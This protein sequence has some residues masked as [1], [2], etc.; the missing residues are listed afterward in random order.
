MNWTVPEIL[1]HRWIHRLFE[2]TVFEGREWTSEYNS[3]L[4]KKVLR[5][6]CGTFCVFELILE[7]YN[8]FSQQSELYTFLY[9]N[10]NPHQSIVLLRAPAFPL[11]D[12]ERALQDLYFIAVASIENRMPKADVDVLRSIHTALMQPVS[13]GY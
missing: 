7:G 5:S 4:N 6:D 10:N 11:K 3:S 13:V 12:S 9:R 8:A 2:E 1:V